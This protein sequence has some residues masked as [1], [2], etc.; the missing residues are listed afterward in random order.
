MILF[1][2]VS[3]DKVNIGTYEINVPE[4]KSEV[5]FDLPGHLDATMA[6]EVTKMVATCTLIPR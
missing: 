6:S 3:L 2:Q 5:R 1:D 4:F